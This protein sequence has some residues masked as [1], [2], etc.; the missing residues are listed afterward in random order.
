[1][2]SLPGK[3]TGSLFVCAA[4]LLVAEGT[5]RLIESAARPA[6]DAR[7]RNDRHVTIN[8]GTSLTHR[9]VSPHIVEEELVRLGV[10]DPWVA[11]VYGKAATMTGVRLAYEES[12]HRWAKRTD[13]PGIIAIEVRGGGLNDHYMLEGEA[14]RFGGED[15]PPAGIAALFAPDG[16]DLLAGRLLGAIRLVRGAPYVFPLARRA[17]AEAKRSSRGDALTEYLGTFDWGRA[18]RGFEA[19]VGGRAGWRTEQWRE[20]YQGRILLDYAV[21]GVQT[22]VLRALIRLVKS[23]GWKPVLYIMPVSDI[24]LRFYGAGEYDMFLRTVH[25]VADEEGVA[26]VDFGQDGDFTRD[27]FRDTHHLN[28][29]GAAILSR[30]FARRVILPLLTDR[31]R[32]VYRKEIEH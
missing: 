26:L 17:L 12:V 30:R 8:V 9:G 28:S 4:V 7:W 5:M 13:R 1:M 25:S 27:L 15:S 2:I 16:A 21:G 29:E 23:D 18:G 20:R 32:D 10:P 19:Y 6:E 11:D 14:A 24:H 31:S 22:E 3:K